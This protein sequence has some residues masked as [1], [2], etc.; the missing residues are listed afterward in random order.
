MDLLQEIKNDLQKAVM[1]GK[2]KN[3]MRFFKTGPGEYGEG[4]NFIGVTVPEQ[5]K[6]ARRYYKSI[7][8]D[9]LEKLLQDPCHEYRLT[10]LFML[11]LRYEKEN[12]ST[13]KAELVEFYLNNLDHVNNWDLVDSSAPYILGPHLYG[14]NPALLSELVESGELWRQ[15]VAVLATAYF[16]KQGKFDE[17]LA[18]AEKLLEHP[19]DLIHKAVGWML[20]EVGNR[21][22]DCELDFLKKHHHKMPRTML[23]YAIEKFE[24]ELRKK[25][26]QGQ[27]W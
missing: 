10:A 24:P 25:I 16:I 21:D 18:L 13:I 17:T 27:T 8:A 3:L 19:H 4:D 15:R 5:R 9:E 7:D 12:S 6:I 20:R 11:R 22:L 1:P 26:I 14:K 23:R 2:A